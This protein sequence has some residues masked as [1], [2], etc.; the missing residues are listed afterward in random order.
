MTYRFGIELEGFQ[1]DPNG[2]VVIPDKKLPTDGFQGLVEFRTFGA[3][4][5]EDSAWDIF[6]LVTENQF[7]VDFTLHEHRFSAKEKAK[8]YE[9]PT[10]K[11][12]HRV[13]N[14]Y[15]RA[16]KDLKGKTIASCQINISK[17]ISKSHIEYIG[18]API[19]FEDTFGLLDVY[20]IVKALDKEFFEEIQTSR[21]QAGMYSVKDNV[22]LEYRSLPNFVFPTKD[23]DIRQFVDRINSAL[24]KI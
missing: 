24:E 23:K 19:K 22:R 12:G 4:S 13:R 17:L 6:R 16:P 11:G 15:G 7:N 20:S 14:I 10:L 2:L 8:C 9:N 1:V 21:R 3:L 18:G 5:L